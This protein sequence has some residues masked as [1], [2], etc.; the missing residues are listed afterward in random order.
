MK[1][2]RV[3]IMASGA[4]TN[5]EALIRYER[6]TPEC[7]YTVVLVVTNKPDAGVVRVA[8]TYG[9]PAAIVPFAQ[10]EESVVAEELLEVFSRH[11][12]GFVC[13]AGFLRKIPLTV[14]EVFK[15][16]IIN[17]H[18]SL[19]PDFGGKGMYGRHVFAAVLDSGVRETGVTIHRVSKEYDDGAV[20]FRERIPVESGETIEGL[21]AKTRVAEHRI[22]PLVLASECRRL[23]SEGAS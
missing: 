12:V 8:D 21:E 15:Q 9:V 17:I 22:Y 16:K 6:N 4:G 1:Q 20:V 19:L 5:A 10:R 18:P 3:A 14:A 13:L 11:D 7:P 23:Q 2:V